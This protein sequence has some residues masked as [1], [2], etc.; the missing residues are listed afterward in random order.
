M[1]GVCIGPSADPREAV[2]EAQA[3]RLGVDEV[4]V[5]DLEAP[6]AE[7]KVELEGTH[8]LVLELDLQRR[9]RVCVTGV[10]GLFGRRMITVMR[11]ANLDMVEAQRLGDGFS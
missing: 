8:A 2:L 9:V 5:V 6:W 1:R 3:R 7:V 10:E 4:D 11:T